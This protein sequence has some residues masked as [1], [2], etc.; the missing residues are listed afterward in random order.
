[1]MSFGETEMEIDLVHTLKNLAEARKHDDQV[2][3]SGNS[4]SGSPYVNKESL[5]GGIMALAV[6][7]HIRRAL[8]DE[9][10]Y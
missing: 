7:A 6:L 10:A 5:C 4:T 2:T 9:I 3:R 8:V 1:M